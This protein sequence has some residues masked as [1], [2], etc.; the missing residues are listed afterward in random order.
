MP[1]AVITVLLGADDDAGSQARFNAEWELVGQWL[2]RWRD[3]MVACPENFEGCGCC[4]VS[5]DVDAPQCALE[6]LPSHLLTGTW[7]PTTNVRSWP[8]AD[9]N[10]DPLLPSEVWAI[11]LN[12]RSLFTSA[13][14]GFRSERSG[15]RLPAPH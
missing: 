15:A 1:R 10:I 9:M 7:K 3:N 12:P 6:E 8:K 2:D 4:F 11:Q 14:P 5:W 13:E